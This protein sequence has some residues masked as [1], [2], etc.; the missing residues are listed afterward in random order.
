MVTSQPGRAVVRHLEA[1]LKDSDLGALRRLL[2]V[3]ILGAGDWDQDSLSSEDALTE[4]AD[5][6]INKH[7][8]KITTHNHHT[9]LNLYIYV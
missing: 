1:G 3:Q 8:H 5:A 9:G 2:V 4:G 6:H 7:L